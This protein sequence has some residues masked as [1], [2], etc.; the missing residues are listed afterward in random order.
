MFDDHVVNEKAHQDWKNI[1]LHSCHTEIFFEV[2]E[3][4]RKFSFLFVCFFNKISLKA[5]SH[6]HLVRKQALKYYKKWS[7]HSSNIGIFSE[8]LTHDFGRKMKILS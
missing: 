4:N 5:M 2:L 8:G 3:K 1:D 7:L 6:D